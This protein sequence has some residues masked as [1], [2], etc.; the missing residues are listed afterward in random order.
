MCSTDSPHATGCDYNEKWSARESMDSNDSGIESCVT[1]LGTG[2]ENNALK[3]LEKVTPSQRHRKDNHMAT[4]K[5]NEFHHRTTP[6]GKITSSHSASSILNTAAKSSSSSQD[7]H[8]H[9]QKISL[10]SQ[11]PIATVYNFDAAGSSHE[12]EAV[13]SLAGTGC[14]QVKRDDVVPSFGR[15]GTN[16]AAQNQFSRMTCK[17]DLA[18]SNAEDLHPKDSSKRRKSIAFPLQTLTAHSG[19]QH[20]LHAASAPALKTGK[21]SILPAMGQLRKEL[22]GQ[23][24]N[25]GKS[26][27]RRTS[28]LP[29]TEG[30][31]GISFK[32]SADKSHSAEFLPTISG[33]HLHAL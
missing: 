28:H 19:Q 21:K 5:N 4:F 12:T 7:L 9:P 14:A 6:P 27:S 2:E 22:V 8:V 31:S 10:F 17:E 1:C 24:S 15:R 30:I 25:V 11:L 23:K 29:L 3:P 13:I 16:G 32:E 26:D 20:H 18:S 33:K